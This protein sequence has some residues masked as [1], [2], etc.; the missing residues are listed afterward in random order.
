MSARH[1]VKHIRF[2]QPTQF[3]VVKMA[4]PGYAKIFFLNKIFSQ[5]IPNFEIFKKLSKFYFSSFY[6]FSKKNISFEIFKKLSKFYFSSFYR[7]SKKKSKFWDFKNFCTLRFLVSI[8]RFST[9]FH[10]LQFSGIRKF[11]SLTQLATYC[12]FG[13]V[14]RFAI[15]DWRFCRK[16]SFDARRIPKIDTRCIL[17]PKEIIIRRNIC[18]LENAGTFFTILPRL[19]KMPVPA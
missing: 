6:R 16:W 18:T 11:T 5:I 17:C 2:V 8:L 10:F 9:N 4:Y 3:S 13:Q 1:Y 14:I 15:W 19:S 12:R 7:F